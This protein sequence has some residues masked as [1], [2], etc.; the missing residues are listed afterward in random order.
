MKKLAFF[1]APRSVKSPALKL[2]DLSL[3]NKLNLSVIVFFFP[4]AILAYYLIIEKDGLIEF[5]QQE[6]AGVH[7]LDA[8]TGA[9]AVLTKPDAS[10]NDYAHAIDALKKAE[11]NDGGKLNVTQ[12]SN[13]ATSAIEGLSDGKSIV[14]AEAKLTDLITTISDN[15]NITLDPDKDAYFVGDILV[16][17]GPGVL[18]QAYNLVSATHDLNTDK[19][20]EHTTAFAEARDGIASSASG[21]ATDITKASKGNTDGSVQTSL[22]S[23]ARSVASSVD[24]IITAAKANNLKNVED[25]ALTTNK[26]TLDL[27]AKSADEMEHLLNQR[28]AGFHHVLRTRLIISFIFVVVGS[29]ISFITVRSVSRSLKSI[30][31]LMGELTS[32]KLDLEIPQE[33]RK[34]EVG[35]LLLALKAFHGASIERERARVDETIRTQKER[36]KAKSTAELSEVFKS[37]VSVALTTLGKAVAQLKESANTMA[38]DSDSAAEQAAGVTL[39]SEQASSNV[40]T[41]AAASEELSASIQEISRNINQSNEVAARAEQEAKKTREKVMALSEAT[42]KIG[43]VVNLINQIAGQTNLLALNAT[44]EA[45]RAGEAGKGFAV[46]ASEVKTLANQTARATEDITG[47]I[48]A[49]QDSVK[50]VAGAM[51][52]IDSTIRQINEIAVKTSAA[53]HEQ[54]AATQE[55]ARNITETANVTSEVT[56]NIGGISAVISNT[57]S[58]AQ[59]V[60]GAS[61]SLNTETG[62]L[63]EDIRSYLMA[64]QTL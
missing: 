20:E 42:T 8:A 39:A 25:A 47:H 16:N 48:A 27:I 10:K 15:S 18:S 29:L 38:K 5:T 63:D 31:A 21:I 62:K 30:T 51:E 2:Q 59:S 61:T 35:K 33:E 56:S 4:V 1:V 49:I 44:I 43:D 11:Q 13:D 26:Q 28:I 12:K 55:I 24:E 14:D 19:S 34:D 57:K 32:G 37:S 45:A 9:L 17:Q 60:L 54:G 58:V 6:I 36:S 50:D 3:S 40:R 23:D 46:V 53:V 7:Y 41:V 52:N 64:I 22:A